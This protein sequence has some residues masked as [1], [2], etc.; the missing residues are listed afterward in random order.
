M[1]ELKP[2]DDGAN[3]RGFGRAKPAVLQIEIVDDGRKAC[4]ARRINLEDGAQPLERAALAVMTELHAEHVEFDAFVGSWWTNS[5]HRRATRRAPGGTVGPGSGSGRGV[6]VNRRVCVHE[7]DRVTYVSG[8]GGY[9][10]SVNSADG[11]R[12]WFR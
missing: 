10:T 11:E 9:V 6:M 3:R 4:D 7:I 2:L 12:S 5:S 1:C 8:Y